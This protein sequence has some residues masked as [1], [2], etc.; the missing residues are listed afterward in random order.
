M[1]NLNRDD[2]YV[3][4]AGLVPACRGGGVVVAAVPRQLGDVIV[5]VASLDPLMGGV[6]R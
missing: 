2:S 6:D 5:A 1:V 4:A 3:R